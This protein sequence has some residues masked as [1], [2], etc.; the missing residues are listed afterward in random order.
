MG[1]IKKF[2]ILFLIAGLCFILGP[3]SRSGSASQQAA[4]PQ[5]P[6][7]HEVAVTLKLIQVYVTDKNGNPV[8]DLKNSD[9]AIFD[10]GVEKTITE[11]EKHILA[12]APQKPEPQ[13]PEQKIVPTA[14]PPAARVTSLSRKFF[15]FLDFAFNNQKGV[16]KAREAA[17]HFIDT[18][19]LPDDDVG[20]LSY[21]MLKGLTVHEYLTTNHRKAREAVEAL[22][23]KGS[24]GRAEDTEE[25][26]WLTAGQG[27]GGIYAKTH[28]QLEAERNESK[29]QAQNFI[30]KMTALAKALRF[31]PGQKNM[32]LFSTGIPSSLLFGNRMVMQQWADRG[33]TST[34]FKIDVGDNNLITKNEEMLKELTAANCTVFT[35]DT[36]EA[37]LIPSLFTYD[38]LTFEENTRPLFTMM[39]AGTPLDIYKDNNITGFYTLSKTST[40]TG[41]KYFSNIEEYEKNL[42]QVQTMTGTY[43]VLGYYISEQR[44][45]RYHD[46]KVKVKK[47]GCEVRAQTGYFNPKPFREYST[48]E[49]ELHLFDLALSDKPQLQ[50]PLTFPM[51]V[52]SFMV[53]EETRLQLLSK[54]PIQ[55]MEKFSGKKVELISLVFDE[56]ENL[57]CLERIEADLTKYRGMDVFYASGAS[58]QP[59][60][61]KCRL[62]IRDLETG[63]GAVASARAAVAQKAFVGLSLH[64]PLLLVPKSNFAYLETATAKKKEILTWKDAY[65]YDRAQYSPLIGEAPKGALKIFAVVPCSVTGIAQPNVSM[66]AYLND[67]VSGTSMPLSISVLNKTWKENLEVRLLEFS[68]NNVPPGKY[69][70]YLLAE[71][72]GTKAV[73][74]TQIALIINP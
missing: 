30:L 31:I 39:G 16:A 7:Q 60:Q 9:F 33:S 64:S 69:F 21:S 63:D 62:V 27:L 65:P 1:I 52:L 61:Y 48:L 36:R 2:S 41:G 72:T 25:E 14:L 37:A 49:K 57:A 19:L 53:G 34:Q 35:F 23:A 38:K 66:T 74:H 11:F 40:A 10:N 67:S 24:A 51:N 47:T 18:Q 32:I 70:L 13:P 73:S 22:D 71:D 20:V 3:S 54:I 17:L 28:F 68:L 15:I 26:Y 8:K 45:G 29:T 58:L 44:D 6:L 43:Y 55:V 42:G 5:K 50:T 56:N 59:G 46:Y 12:A 4:Q